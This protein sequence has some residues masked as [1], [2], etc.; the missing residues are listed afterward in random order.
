VFRLLPQFSSQGETYAIW[1]ADPRF[2]RAISLRSTTKIATRLLLFSALAVI[3]CLFSV[4]TYAQGSLSLGT[5][6]T[7][8][9]AT[10]QTTDGWYYHTD[11]SHNTHPLNCLQTTV[12]NCASANPWHLTF[13]Y[14][15]PVGIV[16][17]VTKEPGTIVLFTGD[18]GIVQLLQGNFGF[19][20]K[21]FQAG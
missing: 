12:R 20:D 1:L 17:T 19:A 3:G 5:L 15:S 11:S 6:D 14:L 9:T 2:E 10:C 8:T 16:P 4:S 13:G 18:G 21:Y 7:P